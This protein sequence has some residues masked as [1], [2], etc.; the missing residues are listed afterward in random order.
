MWDDPSE[1]SNKEAVFDDFVKKN[2]DRM[3]A[4]EILIAQF[5]I[6]SHE[7]EALVEAWES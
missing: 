5:D 2:I 7:A 6:S 3:D 4:I 1:Y